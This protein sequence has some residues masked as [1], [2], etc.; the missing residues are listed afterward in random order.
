[1][2]KF[3]LPEKIYLYTYKTK[4]TARKGYSVASIRMVKLQDFIHSIA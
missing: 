1:M 2:W 4:S 3:V